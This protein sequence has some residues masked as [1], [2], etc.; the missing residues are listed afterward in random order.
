M[1][2]ALAPN[3][4]VGAIAPDGRA[5]RVQLPNN[6]ATFINGIFA[7]S[8]LFAPPPPAAFVLPGTSLGIFPT[9]LIITAVWSALFIAAVGYGT[10]TRIRFRAAYR[11]RSRGLYVAG[12]GGALT[13]VA[14]VA[15]DRPRAPPAMQDPAM[16]RKSMAS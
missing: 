15:Y 5:I 8:D 7:K 13:S 11:R 10:Y 2:L 9:G 14:F 12:I 6:E 3:V 16:V 4:T 1:I